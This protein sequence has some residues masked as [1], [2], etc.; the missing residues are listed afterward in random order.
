M[1]SN[2]FYVR[3]EDGGMRL[4]VFLS[5]SNPE[6]SRSQ[7]QKLIS[8][9]MVEVNGQKTQAK[10][11]VKPKDKIQLTVPDPVE[12]NV[13]PE[14]I[15]L[16][17]YY[18]DEDLIVVNKPRGMVVHPADGNYSGTMV[19]ALLYHCRDLS[20]I[21]GV[22]RPGIVHRLDKDTSG[23]LM[24]AKN[25]VAHVNLAEQLKDRQVNRRYL[26]L[27]H[28]NIREDSGL[29]DAPIGRDPKDRQKMAVVE[30]NSKPAVTHYK[31]LKRFGKYTL[32]ELR[33]ETGRTHQIRVHMKYIGYP[34]VG[35]PK[36]GPAKSH[37][38]LD[39]Q[40]LHAYLLGF[41]HPRTGK[42][43]EFESPLPEVLNLILE[44]LKSYERN[45]R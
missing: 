45:W 6:M 38:N 9:N 16:E 3:E 29:V 42:Y 31:I 5:I 12:L 8:Q 14:P 17:V 23:L 27:L 20:G 21:N 7:I 28:G 2:D 4:D 36:Y 24:V 35:D 15:D 11:K 39:G 30:R 33:L 43:L 26:A 1:K 44:K 22:L 32:V 10:Y 13:N 25:D 41:N 34:V 40:F 18:E 19:N 37:F